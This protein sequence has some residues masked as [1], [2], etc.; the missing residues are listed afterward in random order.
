MIGALSLSF[1]EPGQNLRQ[2]VSFQVLSEEEPWGS[3]G[4]ASGGDPGSRKSGG[5][6]EPAGWCLVVG[7]VCCGSRVRE[8]AREA[9]GGRWVRGLVP[10]SGTPEVSVLVPSL[11]GL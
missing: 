5:G 1:C 10:A 7:E 4:P 6:L 11:P 2:P 8:G 9:A 3:A